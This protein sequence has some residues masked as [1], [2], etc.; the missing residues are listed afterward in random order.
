MLRCGI[1]TVGIE[2]LWVA[3]TFRWSFRAIAV[4]LNAVHIDE[5]MILVVCVVQKCLTRL[6][7]G[8]SEMC[9]QV[10]RVTKLPMQAYV[11]LH[12]LWID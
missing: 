11:S 9:W 6:K 5:M 7:H 10:R 4:S 8:Y 2:W 12:V 3:R 1:V